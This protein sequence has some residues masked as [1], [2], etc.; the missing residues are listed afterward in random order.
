MTARTTSKSLGTLGLAWLCGCAA[1][2]APQGP[3]RAEEAKPLILPKSSEAIPGKR[4]GWNF[5][6]VGEVLTNALGD[7]K[8]IVAVMITKRCGWCRIYLAHVLRCD[9]LNAFAGQAHFV[10]LYAP[11]SKPD[12]KDE[13]QESRDNK[14]FMNLLKIQGYPATAIVSV[15]NKTFSPVGK[16]AG[17][18]SEAGL[19]ELLTAVGLRA[20]A[21]APSR[22]QSAAV[23]LP[24]PSSC[25]TIIPTDA[26]A[27]SAPVEVQRGISP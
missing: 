20:A 18:T 8:L 12:S 1:F 26:L 24:N 25:G 9:G 15:K 27:A 4:I 13:S 6:N 14:Q 16:L 10:I 11:E 17:A 19:I 23:G 22:G 7:G 5:D 3:A 2:A 21:S